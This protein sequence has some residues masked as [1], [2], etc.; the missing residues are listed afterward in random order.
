MHYGDKKQLKAQKLLITVY[1]DDYTDCDNFDPDTKFAIR[2][3]SIV[4]AKHIGTYSICQLSY[5]IEHILRKEIPS[6]KNDVFYLVQ[7]KTDGWTWKVLKVTEITDK[8]HKKN[9]LLGLH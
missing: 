7:L 8:M 2:V 3:E 5:N 9:P 1:K 4:E 6:M